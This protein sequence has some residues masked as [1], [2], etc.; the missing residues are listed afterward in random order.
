M[1]LADLFKNAVKSIEIKK[2][3]FSQHVLLEA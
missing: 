1:K 3:R 2:S